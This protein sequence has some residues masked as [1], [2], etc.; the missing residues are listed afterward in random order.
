MKK[1]FVISAAA[2]VALAA[3]TKT[4]VA[5]TTPDKAITFQVA[6]YASQTQ[7][8]ADDSHGHISLITD[9]GIDHFTTNAYYHTEGYT[10]QGFMVDQ[11]IE[12]RSATSEWAPQGREYY[13][14]KTGYIN[15]F[16]YAGTQN[17][18]TKAEGSITYTNKTIATTDNI[19]VADAAYGYSQSN[20]SAIH[21][22]DGVT[23]GVPTLF[24]HVLAKVLFDVVID[25]TAISDANYS[26]KA[27]I[28][29]AKL[30][31]RNQ[32]SLTINFAAPDFSSTVTPQTVAGNTTGIQWVAAGTNVDLAQDS[33][34][35]EVEAAA[36]AVTATPVT[37]IS[38]SAVLPQDIDA[39]DVTFEMVYVFEST[40][41]DGVNPANTVTETVT[42]P[43]TALYDAAAVAASLAPSITAWN[44]N[45][46]YKYHII[47]K[48]NE[49][50]RFDPA[51]VTWAVVESANTE[52]NL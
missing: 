5:N 42:V 37:L 44:M 19:L 28:N 31:Y 2:L 15:F 8:K 39:T 32:G 18:D 45:T 21:A 14:P 24:N 38:E 17:P 50:I 3:C 27:T 47:I 43:A 7:T 11:V 6:N 10:T 33:A 16:S 12:W 48:P 29:N 9:E 25:A 51:V 34:D 20:P 46:I 49:P 22:L 1:F 40:Y 26:Y 35:I 13:W 36:G 4:E 52:L 41:D 30:N 23:A